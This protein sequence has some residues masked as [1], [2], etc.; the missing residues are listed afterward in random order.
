M[1]GFYGKGKEKNIKNQ[2]SQISFGKSLGPLFW[3][4]FL[5]LTV[6]KQT[7]QLTVLAN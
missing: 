4:A 1:Y 6:Q 7:N 3:R 2:P 5:L